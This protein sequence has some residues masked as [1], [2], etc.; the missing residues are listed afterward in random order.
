MKPIVNVFIILVVISLASACGEDAAGKNQEGTQNTSKNNTKNNSKKPRTK[1]SYDLKSEEDGKESD[2][3]GELDSADASKESGG[4]SI[5]ENEL[6]I[7]IVDPAGKIISATITTQSGSPA[8]GSFDVKNDLEG[9]RISWVSSEGIYD[10]QS[11]SIVLSTC[12]SAVGEQAVGKF[13]DVVLK[14][15]FGGPDRTINGTFDLAVY[16]KV[17]DLF[18]EENL[19]NNGSQN[20]NGGGS[21]SDY[22]VCDSTKGSCCPYAP[23]IGSCEQKCVL[24]PDCLGVDPIACV[25]CLE[26][27][28][29]S[30]EVSAECKT[31]AIALN[32]CTEEANC[33]GDS[34]SCEKENCCSEIQ[35]AW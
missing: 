21:C 17:G 28:L 34:L 13:K 9:T 1:S 32:L 27:C 29:D 10:G 23:C 6:F 16:S 30:C 14:S 19:S 25:T 20:N 3:K 18:C 7:H 4:A 31:D 33:Q 26:S 15:A 24:S 11:G 2:I 8:P 12:P 22:S 35:K 5:V